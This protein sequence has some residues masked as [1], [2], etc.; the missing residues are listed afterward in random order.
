M[1][2]WLEAIGHFASAGQQGLDRY[3]QL[4]MMNE[5]Q[6]WRKRMREMEEQKFGQESELHSRNLSALDD[7]LLDRRRGRLQNQYGVGQRVD[8]DVAGEFQQ[9]GIG[10]LLQRQRIPQMTAGVDMSPFQGFTF[11]QQGGGVEVERPEETLYRGTPQQQR[12][13][14]TFQQGQQAFG[15]DRQTNALQRALMGM[16]IEGAGIGNQQA[17]ESLGRMGE[18]RQWLQQQGESVDPRKAIGAAA[19]FGVEAPGGFESLMDDQRQRSIAAL[20]AGA[21]NERSMG[22]NQA[23]IMQA[24]LGLQGKLAGQGANLFGTLT[25]E[26]GSVEDAI[27]ATQLLQGNPLLKSAIMGGGQPQRQNNPELEQALVDKYGVLDVDGYIRELRNDPDVPFF[28]KQR[29]LEFLTSWRTEGAQN[30]PMASDPLDAPMP[31]RPSSQQLFNTPY[32]VR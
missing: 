7:A 14:M 25:R 26:L 32:R 27:A 22:A 29:M 3:Q 11:D 16:Q 12:E 13:E 2:G 9:L 31:P 20:Q 8:D 21:A 15:D 17:R 30:S 1:A 18:Y 5:E 19:R 6:Q 24:L 4:R 28:E 23:R 10:G